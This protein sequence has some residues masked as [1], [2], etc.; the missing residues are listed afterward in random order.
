MELFILVF[1]II[2]LLA[3]IFAQFSSKFHNTSN[4]D[5]LLFINIFRLFSPN[6]V[7]SDIRIFYRDLFSNNNQSEL[8]EFRY[9]SNP[10]LFNALWFFGKP[11]FLL[12]YRYLKG[13]K[14]MINDN[15]GE[16]EIFKSYYYK[17]IEYEILKLDRLQSILSRQIIFTS[18]TSFLDEDNTKVYLIKNIKFN[19][20]Q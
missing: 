7:K 11:E 13:I 2:I 16:D 14:L 5:Y 8:I 12:T 18:H 9:Y 4:Y 1:Y 19:N 17:R 10:K 6:P 20:K 15:K 3:N